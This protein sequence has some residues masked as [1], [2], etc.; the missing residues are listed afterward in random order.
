MNIDMKNAKTMKRR[1]FQRSAIAPVG[2]VAA[3]SMNTIW[4]RNSANTP[5][6]VDVA[7]QEEALGADQLEGLAEEADVDAR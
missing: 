1:D 6:V 2:M 4:N 5:H 3:V 7:A